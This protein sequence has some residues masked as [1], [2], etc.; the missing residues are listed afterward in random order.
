MKYS[1][2]VSP[3]PEKL[4]VVWHTRKIKI[5]VFLHQGFVPQSC[6]PQK[7]CPCDVQPKNLLP[8]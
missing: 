8:H 2:I 1:M 6:V 7:L 5:P 3:F 4:F